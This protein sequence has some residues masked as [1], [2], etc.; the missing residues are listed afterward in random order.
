MKQIGIA[1]TMFETDNHKYPDPGGI[2]EGIV[3]RI[4]PSVDLV[5][6]GLSNGALVIARSLL[7]GK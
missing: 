6:R 1:L 5:A 4:R 7:G 2:P 3:L